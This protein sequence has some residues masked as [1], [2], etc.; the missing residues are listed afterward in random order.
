MVPERNNFPLRPDS[1]GNPTQ[2][3]VCE[4]LRGTRN[5][6][7]ILSNPVTQIFFSLPNLRGIT[8]EIRPTYVC[9]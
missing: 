6:L 8:L 7:E 3:P 5:Y 1:Q 2:S 4:I 9:Y